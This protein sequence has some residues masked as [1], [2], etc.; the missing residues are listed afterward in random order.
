MQTFDDLRQFFDENSWRWPFHATPAIREQGLLLGNGSV[1][2]RMGRN[3]SGEDLL[4]LP[5]DEERLLAL[6]SAVCGRQISPRVMHY[7]S[8]AS[9]QWR[10]GDKVMAQIELA[11]AR[12]PRLE[13]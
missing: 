4:A 9:E 5:Q 11:F 13:T 2:A 12:F 8:R 1:L 10:R 7:V 6:L 3:R